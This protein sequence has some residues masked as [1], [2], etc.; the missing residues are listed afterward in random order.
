MQHFLNEWG[1]LVARVF[2]SALFIIS[3]ASMAMN[4]EGTAMFL[5]SLTPVPGMLMALIAVVIKV[6]GGLMLLLGWKAREA[7]WAL[8]AFT[9]MTIVLAHRDLAD[10][11]QM[12]QALKNLSIMG[13]LLMVVIH[14]AGAKALGMRRPLGGDMM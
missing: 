10:Q 12:T 7:A 4:F 13:G 9:F 14:G 5:G 3:G 11:A 2:L 8:I 6:G 1:S